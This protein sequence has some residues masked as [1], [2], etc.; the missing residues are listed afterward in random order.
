MSSQTAMERHTGGLADYRAAEG[1]TVQIPF[2]GPI[3]STIQ[4]ILGGY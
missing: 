2:K 1:K 4:D 3:Q